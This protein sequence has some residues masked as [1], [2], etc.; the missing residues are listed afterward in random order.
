MRLAP[1]FRLSPVEPVRPLAEVGAAAA[2]WLAV[3]FPYAAGR[4]VG[5][6]EP[7]AATIATAIWLVTLGHA[8]AVVPASP[9]LALPAAL[10]TSS[11][12]GHGCR[13]QSAASRPGPR[14]G[15]AARS[16][17]G[18]V[19][20]GRSLGVVR[21]QD[22]RGPPARARD[23]PWSA[24]R[25]RDEGVESPCAKGF[26]LV[27]SIELEEPPEPEPD[28]CLTTLEALSELVAAHRPD[29]VVLADEHACTVAI[30][31]LLDAAGT[32][33]ASWTRR[34]FRTRLRTRTARIRL[35]GLVHGLVHLRLPVYALVA[36]VR[37]VA[38]AIV[39]VL[40]L[41]LVP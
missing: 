39:C 15:A 27:S 38:A 10:G 30:D 6:E 13:R 33:A 17:R 35:A 5:I 18:C 8:F 32:S 4:P 26:L 24:H 19:R 12:L 40:V 28:R 20:L 36:R 9:G 3:F 7:V 37:L 1:R 21:P 22:V 25:Q 41:P 11:G 16:R 29:L 14:H 2:I 31:R 23:R 34:G